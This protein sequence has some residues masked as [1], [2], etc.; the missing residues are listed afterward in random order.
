MVH[1]ILEFV[2]SSFCTVQNNPISTTMSNIKIPLRNG[3]VYEF[4]LITPVCLSI[5][6]L[7]SLQY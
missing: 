6:I 1:S 3:G 4:I 5:I 2:K 7:T